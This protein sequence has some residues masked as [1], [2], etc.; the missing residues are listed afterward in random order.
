MEKNK[1]NLNYF[2]I[3]LLLSFPAFLVIGPFLSELSMNLINIIFLFKIF[4]NNKFEYLKNKFLIFFILFYLYVFLTIIISDHTDKLYLKH[5]FY[6]RHI[7]FVFAIVDLLKENK[8]LIFLFYKVL[9]ITILIISIDGIIQFFFEFNSLGFKKI[10]PDRL[11]GFFDDK[12]ILGS[13]LAR[14]LPLLIALF[15]LN[16]RLKNLNNLIFGILV[17]ILSFIT[18]ILSGERMAF[19]TT[20]IY[21]IGLVVMLNY[22][23][24]IK[25]FGIFLIIS[26]TLVTVLIS[27]TL[28]DRHYQQTKD[29]LKFNLN[30]EN[31]FS[32]FVFYKDT[33][34]TAFNGYLDS[35]IFGQ[36]ARSFRFFCSEDKIASKTILKHDFDFSDLVLSKEITI[37]NIYKNN[38]DYVKKNE[39]IFSYIDQ[40][41]IKNF[42]FN[43]DIKILNFNLDK[44]IIGKKVNKK[45]IILYFSHTRDGC[46]THPH[47]F[48]LQLLSETGI[49]GF[50]FLISLFLFLIFQLM[51][52]FTHFIFKKKPILNNFQ[53]CLILG[54]VITLLPLIPN[55]NFFNNWL[56]M[57]MFFPAGFYIFSLKK[58][59][60]SEIS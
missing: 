23:G 36:G 39:F 17:I 14:F 15:F 12:M 49:I 34:T 20:F 25:I 44:N 27:P 58:V 55:G 1:F 51:K 32:N 43:H 50:I 53:I 47:N 8:N 9:V 37:K 29:Q 3:V 2:S 46:T 56:S 33:Y 11:T 59:K 52:N 16:L 7:I 4:K 35:K 60:K 31:F 18:I 40:N 10:R 21:L 28:L 54:F 48:Y 42:Y 6:F 5:I 26:I 22:N 30:E 45:N 19:Y 41:E 24:L 57:I 38:Y 13:Y